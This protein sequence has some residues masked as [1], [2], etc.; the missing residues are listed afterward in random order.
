MLPI[1]Y[2]LISLQ[3]QTLHVHI[4]S[5]LVSSTM[6][7]FLLDSDLIPTEP[8]IYVGT[9]E[10]FLETLKSAPSN[11]PGTFFLS[12]PSSSQ[13]AP[14]WIKGQNCNIIITSLP[15]LS[16][17]NHLARIYRQGHLWS[18]RLTRQSKQGLKYIVSA[19]AHEIN[20]SICMIDHTQKFISTAFRSRDQS[21]ILTN[22]DDFTNE[23]QN[24]INTYLLDHHTSCVC[25]PAKDAVHV[26]SDICIRDKVIGYLYCFSRE[27]QIQVGQMLLL[28]RHTLIRFL[29]RNPISDAKLSFHLFAE[30]LF[31]S[32]V[33]DYEQM[34]LLLP[35]LRTCPEKYMRTINV[36]MDHPEEDPAQPQL[37]LLLEDLKPYFP[38]DNMTVLESNIV[39][40]ISSKLGYCPENL[41]EA[42]IEQLLEAYQATALIGYVCTSTKALHINYQKAQMMFPL[43]Q[44]VRTEHSERLVHFG[45]YNPYLIIDLCAKSLHQYL[46]TDDIIYLCPP[47]ILTLTRY[48]QTYGSDLRDVLFN[49][50]IHDRNIAETSKI[51]YMHR[52]TVINKLS[53]IREL[54]VCD[55][56]D[57]YYR[58]H[59]LFSCML[60]RYYENHQNKQLSLSPFI[61]DD[62]K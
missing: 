40:L 23:I 17:H 32:E 16:L 1:E 10:T 11:R 52:N 45:K 24:H 18:E 29:S 39:I 47:G 9:V 15:L 60:I 8:A 54:L 37:N 13:E 19:A 59:L 28:L 44:H 61:R 27:D 49:Y 51:M 3:P 2:F 5:Q 6:G 38:P 53:K 35:R 57:P 36:H 14:D 22:N 7:I 48:D 31:L 20:S 41:Q 33:T 46:N 50:L 25:F 4:V 55:F 42:A 21:F 34:Q 43:V 56:D 58:F 62:Y 12:S 26:I 30:Q